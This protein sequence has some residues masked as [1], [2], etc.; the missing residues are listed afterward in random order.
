M[1]RIGVTVT[2][3]GGANADLSVTSIA[4]ELKV[5]VGESGCT[6]KISMTVASLRSLSAIPPA[7][8]PAGG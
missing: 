3:P 2:A 1:R 5:L 7:P 4:T 6:E 8:F